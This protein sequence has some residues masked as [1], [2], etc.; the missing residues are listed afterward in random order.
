[1]V[2]FFIILMLTMHFRNGELYEEVYMKAQEGYSIP[3]GKFLRLKK[4]L[5]GLKQASQQWYAKLS[6][7]LIS[8]VF[9]LTPLDHSV[10]IKRRSTDTTAF[11]AILMHVDDFIVVSNKVKMVTKIKQ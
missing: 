6:S 2:C 3:L 1:M 11:I 8:W 4:S 5:Y 10:F 7:S 9:N